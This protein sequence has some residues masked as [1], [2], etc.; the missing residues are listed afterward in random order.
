MEQIAVE[1]Y[2]NLSAAIRGLEKN[3]F[4][5]LKRTNG[6]FDLLSG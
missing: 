3:T 5:G 1:W 4:A 6:P 2:P